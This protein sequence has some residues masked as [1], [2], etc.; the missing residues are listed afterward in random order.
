MR[1]FS[2]HRQNP[3][4]FFPAVSQEIKIQKLILN[5]SEKEQEHITKYCEQLVEKTR[6]FQ[7]EPDDHHN[8]L[9]NTHREIG[10]VLFLAEDL[11]K[12]L[13]HQD[14]T[15]PRKIQKMFEDEITSI[16]ESLQAI[17]ESHRKA[18]IQDPDLAIQVAKPLEVGGA[19]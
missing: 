7:G 1:D 12:S 11:P 6:K 16:R 13:D 8:I 2:L 17:E 15:T 3:S 14:S 18:G 5:N 9:Q 19:A 10:L 4:S